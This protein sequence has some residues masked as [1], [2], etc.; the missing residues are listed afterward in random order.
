MEALTMVININDIKRKSNKK[1]IDVSKAIKDAFDS[2]FNN[3]FVRAGGAKC[4]ICGQPM[5]KA[6]GCSCEEVKC[7]GEKYTRIKYGDED[8]KLVEVACPG[9]GAKEGHF[10]HYNCDRE[11]CP[12]CGGQLIGCDCNPEYLD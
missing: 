7:N 4:E 3:E 11:E 8:F 2:V 6:D 5:L 1:P 12:A 9:C 10:H